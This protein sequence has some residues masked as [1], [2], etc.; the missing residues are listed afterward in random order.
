MRCKYWLAYVTEPQTDVE[1]CRRPTWSFQHCGDQ[2]NAGSEAWQ[3]RTSTSLGLESTGRSQG[4][5]KKQ[6]NEA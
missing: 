5:P 2:P 4:R 3:E 1:L 6:K